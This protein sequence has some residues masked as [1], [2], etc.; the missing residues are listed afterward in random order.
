MS[1]IL[2]NYDIVH[3]VNSPLSGHIR[4]T[5]FNLP[6][7]SYGFEI[8][9]PGEDPPLI[10]VLDSGI[11]GETPLSTI[12]LNTNNE[13][14]L[15]G[16]SPLIDNIDHGTAVGAFAALGN[17]L[18]S[19]HTASIEADAKLLSIKVIDSRHV[20]ISETEV[21]RLIRKAHTDF[22]VRIFVLTTG[23]EDEKKINSEVSPY[24][25][26]LDNLAYELDILIFISVGNIVSPPHIY[27]NNGL[28]H[29]VIPYPQHLLNPSTSL[30][31]PA[32][33]YNNISCGASAE[34]LE[35]FDN[36]INMTP[37][38]DYPAYYSRR[39][40]MDKKHSFFNS[41]RNNIHLLKPD[42]LFAGGDYDE[43]ISESSNAGITCLSKN[44]NQA[45][46]KSVGTSY[47]APLLA[48]LA[49]RILK[50]YPALS[51]QSIKALLVNSASI[52]KFGDLLNDK[53]ITPEIFAGN[54]SPD[55]FH[56]VFSDDNYVT[57]ILEDKIAPGEIK[58]YPINIPSYLLSVDRT[59]SLLEFNVTLCFSFA[60]L[61]NNQIAYCP[62]NIYFSI[63]KN[64]TITAQDEN[65]V[66]VG[67]NGNSSANIK[68]RQSWSQD[69]YWKIKL[70]SNCQK[71]NFN[72]SKEHIRKENNTFKLAI[73]AKFTNCYWITLRN[74]SRIL[75]ISQ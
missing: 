71:Q 59:K 29:N 33:S 11:S 1:E 61:L 66:L 9:N 43:G 42:I 19:D 64:L 50:L 51:A 63:F 28:G 25:Y 36:L 32:D 40:Y 30:C 10:A 18:I 8:S 23:Y 49:V 46:V 34:N 31:I 12:L 73:N 16:T 56:S 53:S 24:A 68:F 47:A 45:F 22:G 69:Y 62:L 3:T 55:E 67:L 37:S 2:D 41:Y 48:N 65:G 21:V 72:V 27:Q 54:G 14:D 39:F 74:H 58:S 4:P 20:P 75:T 17:K 35:S 57:M 5:S 26:L 15:T 13:F 7:R 70:L 52:P 44:P 6:E 60:P 38:R